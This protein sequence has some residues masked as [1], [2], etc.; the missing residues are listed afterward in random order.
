MLEPLPTIFIA[1]Y[2]F[3]Y[4]D[5]ISGSNWQSL[6]TTGDSQCLFR[7]FATS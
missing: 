1:F 7:F 5:D 4:V 6:L 3:K 2:G